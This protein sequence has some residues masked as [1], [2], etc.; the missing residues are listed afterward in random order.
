[1]RRSKGIHSTLFVFV[2]DVPL[3]HKVFIKVI[4]NFLVRKFGTNGSVV[5]VIFKN[6]QV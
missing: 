3:D 5:A 1:M 4:F 6:E 2:D